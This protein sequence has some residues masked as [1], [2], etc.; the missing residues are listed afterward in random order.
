MKLVYI[1]SPYAGDVQANTEAAKGYC[2]AALEEGVIP[3]APHLLYPQFLEDSDP[4]ERNL[5]LRPGLELLARCDELW[6]CGPEI[7]PGMSRE[8]QFAQGLGIP[9]RQVEPELVMERG[10]SLWPWAACSMGSRAFLSPPAK[11]G[12]SPSGPA[13]SS[14][15]PSG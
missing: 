12:S 13:R 3:I 14:R 1:A 11:Q 5:G 8:I 9:I 2:R 10:I 6:V 7:S 4:A 15:F